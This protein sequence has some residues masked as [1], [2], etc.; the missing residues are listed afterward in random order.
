[1]AGPLALTQLTSPTSA[2]Q[3]TALILLVAID[4]VATAGG[5]WHVRLALQVAADPS[6]LSRR[7][8]E[9]EIEKSLR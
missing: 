3:T 5:R 8:V 6:D 9:D 2:S 1:M 4:H 7:I